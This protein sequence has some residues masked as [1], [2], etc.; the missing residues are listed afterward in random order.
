MRRRAGR[1]RRGGGAEPGVE[2]DG[3]DGA[4]LRV[5]ADGQLEVLAEGEHER[6]R[7]EGGRLPAGGRLQG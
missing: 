3:G 5:E 1:L 4:A 2:L 6:R 7:A